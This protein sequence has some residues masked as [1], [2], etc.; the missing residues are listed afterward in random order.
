ML[1]R[2]SSTPV[3]GSLLSSSFSD[4]PNNNNIHHEITN[5]AAKHHH[6]LPPTKRSFRSSLNFPP[7][8]CNSSP[9]AD[10]SDSN[11]GFRRAQSDGNLEGLAYAS[12]N[13]TEDFNNKSHPNKKFS[14]RNKCLM[15]Q[16]IPSFS[17]SNRSGRR[18]EEDDSDIEDEEEKQY[19]EEN[20]RAR[21]RV[22]AVQGCQFWNVSAD[23]EN[24]EMYLAR[25]LGIG[26]GGGAGGS[27]GEFN[28]AG[29]GGDD[30]GDNHGVEEHYKKMVLENPGDPLFLRNYAQFLY[31]SKQD[32]HGAEEYYSRAILADPGDGEI[33]SQYAKIVWELHHEQDR[34]STYFERA[35]Q[36]SPEDSINFLVFS[37][38]QAAY[39]GFLWETE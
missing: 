19:F 39:A 14:G 18:E 8:S 30:N 34:A 3:L 5:K 1:L 36:V 12:C 23:G 15:L 4:S 32:L 35:V 17:Y 29:S 11:K 38:V 26:G 27:G 20:E 16:T 7:V 37:H 25:G 28:P 24:Q 13:K 6:H 31:Q 10:L 22:V 21:E 2:S 33:L 9:I